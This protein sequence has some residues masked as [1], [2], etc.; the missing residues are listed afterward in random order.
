MTENKE[1]IKKQSTIFVLLFVRLKYVIIYQWL[2]IRVFGGRISNHYVLLH[3]KSEQKV[4]CY[5]NLY[6]NNL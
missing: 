1:T 6:T 3:T 4:I 5:L 2:E